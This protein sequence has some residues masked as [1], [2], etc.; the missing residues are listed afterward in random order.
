MSSYVR[1]VADNFDKDHPGT[2]V[3][4][5]KIYRII[6]YFLSAQQMAA[7]FDPQDPTMYHPYFWGEYDARGKMT[8]ES[9]KDPYLYWQLPFLRV[10]PEAPPEY[11]PNTE[12]I[13]HLN[14][15]ERPRPPVEE[16]DQFSIAVAN[17]CRDTDLKHSKIF[18]YMY[19][20]A[21][22]PNWVRHADAKKWTPQ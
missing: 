18:G 10:H 15:A 11:K 9:E 4:R 12:L 19:L 13:P 7:G 2:Q 5:I 6:H 22:D 8:A 14:V 16:E 21:G 17:A 20:H 1:H 3:Q